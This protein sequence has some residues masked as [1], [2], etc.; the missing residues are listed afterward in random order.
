MLAAPVAAA[1]AGCM[2]WG[3]GSAVSVGL[4]ALTGRLV[5][6]AVAA[7]GKLDVG[8]AASAL[9]DPS[10]WVAAA[11]S[12]LASAGLSAALAWAWNRFLDGRGTGAY[13]LAYL[14][15][16]ACGIAVACL[17]HPMEIASSTPLQ[18][19]VVAGA[20]AASSIIAC[21]Y[22]YLFGYRKERPESD[23]S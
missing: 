17:A 2:A 11:G 21:I 7:G 18:A 3:T 14:V 15:P 22:V 4:G 16:L 13:L 5:S 10:L 19:A 9:A 1:A 8:L 6:A 20:G 23:C 12:A